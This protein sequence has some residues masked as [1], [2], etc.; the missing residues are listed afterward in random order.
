MPKQALRQRTEGREHVI[1]LDPQEIV[2]RVAQYRPVYVSGDVAKPG[3]LTFRPGMTV[4]QVI[5]LG[6]GIGTARST[7]GDSMLVTVDLRAQYQSIA[8]ETAVERTRA[9]RIEAELGMKSPPLH[10][11]LSDLQLPESVLTQIATNETEQLRVRQSELDR[12]SEHLGRLIHQLEARIEILKR[13]LNQ[14]IE[15]IE[16]DNADWER[17]R[18]LFDKGMV[19]AARLSDARRSV[20]LSATRKLQ[21]DAEVMQVERLREEV[22]RKLEKLRE[23]RRSELLAD[24]QQT[25]ARATGLEAKL[26][27][28]RDKLALVG[29]MSPMLRDSNKKVEIAIFRT[30][31][32]SEE[33]LSAEAGTVLAP[34][35][36]VLITL[37][38]E[39]YTA[40]AT[41]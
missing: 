15:G 31:T 40:Q 8:A 12:E 14:E 4:R 24:L 11:L 26:I 34:G 17:L 6:G 22:R 16:I 28:A 7:G 2:I 27:A 37:P 39:S 20:L 18:A 41:P 3:E 21:T 33:R 19:P 25:K 29:D 38:V 10:G 36:V 1:V 23:E 13:Q 9:A 30:T 32:G 5:A 35:D